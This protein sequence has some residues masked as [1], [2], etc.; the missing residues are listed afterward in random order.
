MFRLESLEQPGKT[1]DQWVLYSGSP[2]LLNVWASWRPT[3]RAEHQYLYTLAS[4]G[5]QIVGMNYKNNRQKA[6][7]WLNTLVNPYELSLYDG[8]GMLGLE[9]GGTVRRKPS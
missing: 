6:V 1:F 5:V 7:N 8:D 2:L 4:Q 3:C 9:L